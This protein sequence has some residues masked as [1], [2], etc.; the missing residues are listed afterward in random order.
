V[1]ASQGEQSAFQWDAGTVKLAVALLFAGQSMVFS[2]AINISPSEE[3]GARLV[4]QGVVLAATV[5]VMALLGGPLVRAAA[6]ELLHGRVTVELL[7][8][9]A[10]LGALAASLQSFLTGEG[11]IFFEVVSVLLVVYTFGKQVGARSRAAALAAARAW[12]ESLASCRRLDAHG[13][14]VPTPVAEVLPGDV[15]EVR[16]GELIPVDGLV[17]RGIGFTS[18]AAVSGEAAAV[19]RRPG[20]PVLAGAASHDAT[21]L[22]EAAAPGTARQIDQLLRAV[23]DARRAPTSLQGQADRLAARFVPLIVLCS[24][25]TFA[26]WTW[27]AGWQSGL[28]NAMAVLLVACPC[29]VGLAVPIVTWTTLE[30]LAE[31]GLVARSGDVIERL[32]GVDRAL[33]DKTGTLTEER[34][35]VADLVT[36]EAGAGRTRLL[37]W[38]A[39]VEAQCDHPVARAFAA[40]SPASA[41]SPVTVISLRTEPGAGVIATIRSEDGREHLL[42]VGRPGWLG[43]DGRPEAAGLVAQL[44]VTSGQRID[45]ELDGRLAAA[46]ILTE[47]LRSSARD[48]LLRL[49]ELGLGVTVLTGDTG[50]RAA[51][52]GLGVEARAC[53]S[54]AD[55]Q[56]AVQ[57]LV[58][59]GGRPLFVG[60]GVNDASA[61]ANAH[62]SIGLASGTGL[63]NAAADATLHHGDLSAIPFAVALCRQAIA[64]IRRNL[65]RAVLYNLAGITLAA[66]GL[67]HPVVAALLMVASSLLVAWS[68]SRIG[69]I[70]APCVQPERADGG[71]PIALAVVHGV[72]LAL[73]GLVIV[74]LLDLADPAARWTMAAFMIAGCGLGWL[75][76]RWGQMPPWLDMT[77]GML[78]LGNLGMLFGWWADLGFAP[79]VAVTCHC[80]CKSPLGGVGMWTGMLLLGNLA[81]AFCLRCGAGLCRWAMFVGGNLGMIVGMF[82]AGK[83]AGP[84]WVGAGG[85]L[86]AMS[87]GMIVGML[88]GHFLAL[89]HFGPRPEAFPR[90]D[91]GRLPP[92]RGAVK[93]DASFPTLERRMAG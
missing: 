30:R 28:F 89:R 19:V 47:R 1:G 78:T 17:L 48:T 75:W 50:E 43:S 90:A 3:P 16:P 82:A 83:L 8:V 77:V 35:V 73:Q 93:T 10:I 71:R 4:V 88:A 70:E 55:K 84:Q 74:A 57:D 51:A 22:V 29:A 76:L 56:R 62:A 38:L 9:T 11:P 26:G 59:E 24:V 85:H 5:I 23:E 80:G 2:L 20:D 92:T 79:A 42:R 31:I 21:F 54:A 68:S 40:V 7:F 46:A 6:A 36:V 63:A 45:V 52:L 12:S 53:L 81:M 14:A 37:G 66:L 13:Q 67:L 58:A 60:D 61:L 72:A 69:R 18:E 64:T 49:Q 27:L 39:A 33:F 44:R 34:M 91:R 87:V 32:A 86:L 15:I 41:P 65:N 25:A